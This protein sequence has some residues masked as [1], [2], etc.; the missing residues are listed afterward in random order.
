MRTQSSS[1]KEDPPYTRIAVA[2]SIAGCK[3]DRDVNTDSLNMVGKP[4]NTVD[5][6]CDEAEMNKC[7]VKG[8]TA[9]ERI[10]P[11]SIAKPTEQSSR[12]QIGAPDQLHSE[13]LI[14]I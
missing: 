11:R 6:E 5:A 8:M 9:T 13:A 4:R 3:L 10:R 2:R 14:L 12:N 1:K 7:A